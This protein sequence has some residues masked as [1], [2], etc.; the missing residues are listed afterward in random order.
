MVNMGER[1]KNLRLEKSLTQKQIAERVGVAISAISSYESGLRYPTYDTLV[2]LAN[3]Y[4]VSSDYLIGI[5]PKRNIDVE[6][7]S[8]E[9]VT[10]ISQMVEMLRSLQR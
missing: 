3:I 5:S 8:P 7:L 2:K 1:L 4:H 9:A 6:G 10:L